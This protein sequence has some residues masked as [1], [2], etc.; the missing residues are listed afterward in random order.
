MLTRAHVVLV[1]VPR[2]DDVQLVGEVVTEASLLGIETFHHAVHQ[3]ALADRAAG[4]H[5]AVLPGVQPAVDAE[6]ADLDAVDVDD[7]AAALEDVL[8][9]GNND[10]SVHCSMMPGVTSIVNMNS[11]QIQARA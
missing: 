2:A 4:M 7:H 5:A 9:H 6:D 1:T 8:L 3:L 11:G 10:R